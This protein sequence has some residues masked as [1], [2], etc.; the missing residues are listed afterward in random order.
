VTEPKGTST[1]QDTVAEPRAKEASAAD[2]PAEDLTAAQCVRGVAG[3]IG[4]LGGAWMFDEQTNARGEQLGLSRWS[5]YHCG[6]GGVLGDV[7]ASVVVAAFGFFPP[8]LQSK[9]WNRGRGVRPVGDTAQDYAQACADWGRRT[10]GSLESAGRLADLLGGALAA[11]DV[12][13]LPLFAAWRVVAATGPADAPARLA[14]A[15]QAG[16][17]HRGSCHLVAVVA[18]GIDPLQA[19]VSGRYG[20]RNAEFFGWAPPWPD[21]QVA[22]EAMVEVEAVTD[23]LVEPAFAALPTEQRAELVEGLRALR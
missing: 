3:R 10:F 20:P 5:W 12:A 8:A 1:A 6:R 22:R 2:G 17:E 23:R 13:G 11:V 21:P 4:R 7:D 18:A 19:V 14:L 15:L 9:A 16:R